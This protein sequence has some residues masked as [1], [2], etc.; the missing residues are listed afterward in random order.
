MTGE[1]AVLDR[2]AMDR[3]Y[4]RLERRMVNVLYRWLWSREEAQECAQD[5]FV[6]LW[7][8]KDRVRPETV[9][10]LV[11]SIAL[12]LAWKR[13]RWR[14]RRTWVGLDGR[15]TAWRADRE[16]AAD[17]VRAAVEGLAPRLREVVMLTELGELSYAE[18]AAALGIAEGTVGSRRHE[19]LAQ[20][21]S[22]LGE[23]T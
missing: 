16:L 12:R 22:S 4:V 3:L 11:W 2:V 21:R 23:A 5:A 20:L 10:P 6:Q 18:V 13:R 7:A 9:E 17:G 19:A 15:V 14:E 1:I 8:M